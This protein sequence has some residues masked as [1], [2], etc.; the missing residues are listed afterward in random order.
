MLLFPGQPPSQAGRYS[1]SM[2]GE[3]IITAV[4]SEDSGYYMCQAI[5]VAGS[6]VSKAFLKVVTGKQRYFHYWRMEL[7]LKLV[8]EPGS[9][10]Y[11]PTN[12]T[13]KSNKKSC[14]LCI[15]DVI[16]M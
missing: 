16:F 8:F 14:T 2:R 7:E 5:S 3:L 15:N 10:C 13:K 12:N 4:H 9:N 6:T 1:V 11:I